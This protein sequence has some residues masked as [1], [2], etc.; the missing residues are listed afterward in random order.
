[1]LYGRSLSRCIIACFCVLLV[2]GCGSP[3]AR[4]TKYFN[5]GKTLFGKGDYVKASLEFRNAIQ[6]DPKYLR[7]LVHAGKDRDEEGEHEGGLRRFQ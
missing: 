2:F 4:K 5:K 6:V 7:C 1:M 3:D